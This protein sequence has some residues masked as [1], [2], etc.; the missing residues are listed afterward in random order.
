MSF[1]RNMAF[2]KGM[3]LYRK[4]LGVDLPDERT[5]AMRLSDVYEDAESE[6]RAMDALEKELDMREERLKEREKKVEIKEKKIKRA[7][8]AHEEKLQENEAIDRD[9]QAEASDQAQTRIYEQNIRKLQAEYDAFMEKKKEWEKREAKKSGK[10]TLKSKCQAVEVREE[11]AGM[12]EAQE[13]EKKKLLEEYKQSDLENLQLTRQLVQ[14]RALLTSICAGIK[15]LKLQQAEEEMQAEELP[16]S[17]IAAGIQKVFDRLTGGHERASHITDPIQQLD[18]IGGFHRLA[19]AAAFQN[20][21]N[22]SRTKTK[23]NKSKKCLR[24]N[25]K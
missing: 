13:Q 1:D 5:I 24:K 4:D 19:S 14:Q 8:A 9:L 18:M 25:K 15:E 3:E 2:Q 12:R 6:T 11:M 17:Q 22:A 20:S 23:A 10:N 16:D 7:K 21:G